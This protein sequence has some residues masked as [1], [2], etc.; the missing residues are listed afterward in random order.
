[1]RHK[2]EIPLMNL[3][4]LVIFFK[5]WLS[6]RRFLL[7]HIVS[8]NQSPV[9]HTL[10]TKNQVAKAHVLIEWGKYLKSLLTQQKH[11]VTILMLKTEWH[12]GYFMKFNPQ[13][14][15]KKKLN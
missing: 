14:K 15:K 12:A 6:K 5:P 3:K 8:Y 13:I 7:R 1:M 10:H 11:P 4:K 2:N 9:T